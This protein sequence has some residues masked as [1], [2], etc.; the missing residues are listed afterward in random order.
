VLA[1]AQFTVGSAASDSS[2]RFIY[3]QSTGALFFDADGTGSFEQI[4]IAQLSTG[5]AMTNTDIFVFA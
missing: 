2:T 4:Q 5:L 1:A 3:A